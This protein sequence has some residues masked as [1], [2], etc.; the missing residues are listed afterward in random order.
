PT[1][2]QVSSGRTRHAEAVEIYYDTSSID[3]P[4]L[5]EV[6]FGTHDPTT[7][8]R[9]GPDRGPQYRSV[10]FYQNAQ[11]KELTEN[12]LLKLTE[13]KVFDDPIVTEVL[14]LEKFYV[15]E[16]YHQDYEKYN[17]NNPYVRAVSIPRFNRFKKKFPHLLKD[18]DNH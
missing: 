10:V 17:P 3:F 8:D 18:R 13:Q 4:T 14:P 2:D 15:A 5:L 9:Q 7:K 1:Y 12:Y 6:F 11:E 16:S